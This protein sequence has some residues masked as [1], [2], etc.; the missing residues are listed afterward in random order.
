MLRIAL[1]PV[2][3]ALLL[4][5]GGTQPTMRWWA[6]A[7]FVVAMLTDRLDLSLIHI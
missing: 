5:D 1:V 7:V 2:Y 3:G 6:V 4:S